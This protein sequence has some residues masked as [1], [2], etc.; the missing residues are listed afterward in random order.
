MYA[1]FSP[2]RTL[3]A[4]RVDVR[5]P[6]RLP[7]D[8]AKVGRLWVQPWTRKIALFEQALENVTLRHRAMG[9]QVQ[10]LL[11]D[12]LGRDCKIQDL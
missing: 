7:C 2:S 11:Y 3:A 4:S 6:R 12:H 5:H 9:M 10:A 1:L 8:D